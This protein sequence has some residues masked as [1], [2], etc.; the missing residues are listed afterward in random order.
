MTGRHVL[1]FDL[2]GVL[3]N[4]ELHWIDRPT[5]NVEM[6]RYVRK[7]YYSCK[8]VIIIWSARLWHDTPKTVAWLIE[9]DVPFHGINMEKSATDFYIDDK[10]LAP[11]KENMERLLN[12]DMDDVPLCGKTEEYWENLE[13]YNLSEEEKKQLGKERYWETTD[14]ELEKEAHEI[15]MEAFEIIDKKLEEAK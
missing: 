13:K 5:P 7:L 10:M 1:N 11:T 3:T 4:G 2:D 14:L 6:C 12:E 9:N 8:Y 15:E